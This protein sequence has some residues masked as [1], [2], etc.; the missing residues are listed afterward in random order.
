MSEPQ[1]K[2]KTKKK[3]GKFKKKMGTLNPKNLKKK[4]ARKKALKQKKL[5][6][7]KKKIKKN[8]QTS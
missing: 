4:R 1:K 6:K 2:K 3:D 8:T 7:V 5:L